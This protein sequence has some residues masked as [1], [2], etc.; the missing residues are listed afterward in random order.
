MTVIMLD[1]LALAKT[2]DSPRGV[3]R[4][5]KSSPCAKVDAEIGFD[6]AVQIAYVMRYG[7]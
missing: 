3:F 6:K 4:H 7:A 2:A 5:G 1:L